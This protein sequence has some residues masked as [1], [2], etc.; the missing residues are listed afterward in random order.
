MPAKSAFDV[1]ARAD[2][3]E[4][5]CDFGD[6]ASK[7]DKQNGNARLDG[8]VGAHGPKLQLH[9]TYGTIRLRKGQ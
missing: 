6:L 4:L 3:G 8:S 7:I 5:D 2:R 9:T 1:S